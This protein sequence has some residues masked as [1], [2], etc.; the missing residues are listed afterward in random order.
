MKIRSVI[1]LVGLAVSFALPTFAQQANDL[2][3]TWTLVSVTIV[4]DAMKTDLYG[5]NPQGQQI[6]E[7][8]GR[9]STINA[10][11]ELQARLNHLE[12]QNRILIML[13]CA[14]VA[15]A[16]IA[17]TN[18]SARSSPLVSFGPRTSPWSIIMANHW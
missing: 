15:V 12:R 5:P 4:Q 18:R 1:T 17:A 13:L 16:A 14:L 9:H 10:L 7:A 2:V 3:G 11:V 8:D 6:F